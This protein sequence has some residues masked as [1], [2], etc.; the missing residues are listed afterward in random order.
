MKYDARTSA[1]AEDRE[2][3]EHA[4]ELIRDALLHRAVTDRRDVLNWLRMAR[5][6]IDRV[7]QRNEVST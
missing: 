7:L 4:A 3:L 2:D 5:L 6:E 1:E